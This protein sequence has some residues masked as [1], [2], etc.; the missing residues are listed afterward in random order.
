M[1]NVGFVASSPFFCK[2]CSTKHSTWGQ[3]CQ[4]RAKCVF[5]QCTTSDKWQCRGHKSRVFLLSVFSFFSHRGHLWCYVTYLIKWANWLSRSRT[6][7]LVNM[8]TGVQLLM[9]KRAGSFFNFAS[10]E[11]PDPGYL[12][13]KIGRFGLDIWLK[14][15]LL[16]IEIWLWKLSLV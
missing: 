5:V 10:T 1:K 13:L 9:F 15:R 16:L 8:P 3:I 7:I 11:W 14:I 2:P 12:C 6:S 4:S